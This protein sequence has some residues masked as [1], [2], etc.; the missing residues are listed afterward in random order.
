MIQGQ[1][2]LQ[3]VVDAVDLKELYRRPL[4]DSTAT[5]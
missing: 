1:W 3:S 5:A 2:E 4:L